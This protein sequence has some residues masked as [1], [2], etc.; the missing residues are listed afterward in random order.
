MVPTVAAPHHHQ[1]LPPQLAGPRYQPELPHHAPPVI[2]EIVV[3]MVLDVVVDLDR[4][5]AAKIVNLV[6][7]VVPLRFINIKAVG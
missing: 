1:G 2:I 6:L 5:I 4:S 3:E 7:I